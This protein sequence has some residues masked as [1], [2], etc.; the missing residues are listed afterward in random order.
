MP[1]QVKRGIVAKRQTR[2]Q[3]E[4]IEALRPRVQPI[5]L[6]EPITYKL[7]II[8]PCTLLE[9]TM[10]LL[11][12]QKLLHRR[13]IIWH[14]C[15]DPSP[16]HGHR[17]GNLRDYI[18]AS[19]YVLK[20]DSCV[21]PTKYTITV[22]PPETPQEALHSRI[23]DP[24][25]NFRDL[26]LN[27]FTSIAECLV[28]HTPSDLPENTK[29]A[30]RCELTAVVYGFLC[31][32]AADY[33]A[34][35]P[36]PIS[37][38]IIHPS[39][40]RYN[41]YS[42]LLVLSVN[43]FQFEPWPALLTGPLAGCETDLYSNICLSLRATHL[44]VNAPI[45]ARDAANPGS[46]NQLRSPSGLKLLHGDFGVPENPSPEAFERAFW[47]RTVQYHVTQVWAPLYS[48]FSQGN[49]TEKR[50]IQGMPELT[51]PKLGTSVLECSAVDLYAGI[52]YFA[53]FYLK[54]G[55]AKMLCWEINP[56][57]VEGLRRG[58]H[59][60]DSSRNRIGVRIVKGESE[61]VEKKN[62][63]EEK[64]IVFQE[65]NVN[66]VARI[67]QWRSKIPPVRH[68]NCGLLPTS[69]PSW[70]IAV[71]ALDPIKGGWIHA[72]ENISTAN[73]DQR[74]AEIVETFKALANPDPLKDQCTV[75]CQYLEVVKSFAPGIMHCVL[76]IWIG[77]G[78][79][80]DYTYVNA[81]HKVNVKPA[82]TS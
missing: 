8:V 23:Q 57:S 47:T 20:E 72:H 79:Q 39:W 35:L 78:P 26:A 58:V 28:I 60:N 63:A 13:A 37:S 34:T 49:I 53:L 29:A 25:R 51:F 68:V 4:R 12:R 56:W 70:P 21:V 24:V 22:S 6:P 67:Q 16:Y 44:A 10:I 48:M 27:A 9:Q 32:L 82:T 81:S 62:R 59:A 33:K 36:T 7:C 14:L 75:E 40:T 55:V 2:A 42:Q 46:A 77:W 1:K 38:L 31:N 43:V 66:A 19:H 3:L 73:I 69:S 54:A 52:G 76:D 11:E 15:L 74:R 80:E 17:E 71:A 61:V 50:R 5:E 30:N 45:P 65:D 64:V 18:T 41:Q